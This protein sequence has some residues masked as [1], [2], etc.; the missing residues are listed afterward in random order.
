MSEESPQVPMHRATVGSYGGRVSC[1]PGGAGGELDAL[2]RRG[3]RLLHRHLQGSVSGWGVIYY[4]TYRQIVG[5]GVVEPV[6]S[7][8][9]LIII[10][11]RTCIAVCGLRLGVQGSGF[12]FED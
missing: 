7:P 3:R 6:L 10:S 11:P 2:R 1:V 12:R 4:R 9:L 5:W 8:V